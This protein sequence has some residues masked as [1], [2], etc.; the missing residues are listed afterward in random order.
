MERPGLVRLYRV[1]IKGQSN[2]YLL[3][4]SELLQ[5]YV[6]HYMIFYPMIMSTVEKMT[7][8]SMFG[9][10]VH[11]TQSLNKRLLSYLTG[12]WCP[13]SPNGGCGVVLL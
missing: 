1:K 8:E 9:V 7:I 11:V 10:H 13:A 2:Y 5:V 3:F 12:C 4:E 6:K